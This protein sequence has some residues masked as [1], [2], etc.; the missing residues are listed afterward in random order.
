MGVREENVGGIEAGFDAT[1]ELV[2]ATSGIDADLDVFEVDGVAVVVLEGDGEVGDEVAVGHGDDQ[3]GV[4][5]S[6]KVEAGELD[7]AGE[8]FVFA[9]D[10]E[11]IMV[12]SV[13]V[14]GGVDLGGSDLVG[15]ATTVAGE[16]DHGAVVAA[17]A[18]VETIEVDG[19]V[20]LDQ[21]E[22]DGGGSGGVV[23]VGEGTA[24]VEV[25]ELGAV[26]F[27]VP[28]EFD[29]FDIAE[30]V[31]ADADGDDAGGGVGSERGAIIG[32]DVGKND[33][34]VGLVGVVG[35]AFLDEDLAFAFVAEVFAEIE[36][37]AIAAKELAA[38]GGVAAGVDAFIILI[39]GALGVLNANESGI[40]G[41]LR[42][43]VVAALAGFGEDDAN[44][45]EGDDPE[46]DSGKDDDVERSDAFFGG[47]MIDTAHDYIILLPCGRRN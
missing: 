20:G 13:R 7:G 34:G 32:D 21:G 18:I 29:G 25:A 12:A 17:S 4:A 27:G 40:V 33:A 2:G 15:G 22:G 19:G 41:G 1:E 10:L 38:G 11:G 39:D 45:T 5:A 47:L 14:A 44:E 46:E 26:D 8:F 3:H 30:G 16:E 23:F 31:A 43:V 35:G 36:V 28:L 9:F 24:V 42:E 37:V 6:G